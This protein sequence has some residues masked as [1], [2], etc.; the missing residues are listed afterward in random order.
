MAES[1]VTRAEFV[2]LLNQYSDA[3]YHCGAWRED[4]APEYSVLI[5]DVQSKEKL[6]LRAW[7]DLLARVA[8]LQREPERSP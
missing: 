6:I 8:E 2:K 5:A 1:T 7:D 3:S 4:D